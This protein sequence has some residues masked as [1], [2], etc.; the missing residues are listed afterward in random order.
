MATPQSIRYLNKVQALNALFRGDGMSRSD[1][2]RRLG[3]NRASVGY[4]VQDLLTEGLAIEHPE[5]ERSDSNQR[6]GRPG[7]VVSLNPVGAEFVGVEIGVDHITVAIVDLVGNECR[8]YSIDYATATKSPKIGLRKVT[9]LIHETIESPAERKSR[10]RGV[11][12]AVPGLVRDGVVVNALMLG[13]RDLPLQD[14]LQDT[15][16]SDMKVMVENDANALAIGVTYPLPSNPNETVACLNIENG[17]GG[18][19]AIGGKLFRGAAGFSGEFGQ[20]PLGGKG[21]CAGPFRSGHLESYIGK[22]AVL[23]RYKAN[24]GAATQD[25]NVFI[26]ALERQEKEA[27]KTA[28]DWADR[29]AQGLTQVIHV[30]NPGKIVLGGSVSKIYPHVQH[31]VQNTV[32]KE[33]LAGFPVPDIGLPSSS[34]GGTASGAACLLHQFMFSIDDE[35]VHATGESPIPARSS[36]SRRTARRESSS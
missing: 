17:V 7:I 30:I 36:N 14:I 34:N 13:W 24:G 15:L 12:V 26:Q 11:C 3:L 4:I 25:F 32:K 35:I 19:I 28:Y 6:S 18:G 22:E 21:F 5:A 20:L 9:E 29:L 23:A 31:R 8:R 2:A 1:L 33:F 27:V 10:V 16:G